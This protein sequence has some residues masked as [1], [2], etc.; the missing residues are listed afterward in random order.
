MKKIIEYEIVDHGV[1]HEQYFQGC[2][3]SHTKFDEVYTGIG[4]SLREAL[5]DAD[6][7]MSM[8]L[9]TYLQN[10]ELEE[11]IENASNESLI[12]K[13]EMHTDCGD[14]DCYAADVW[15]YA[16]IRVKLGEK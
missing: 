12:P 15:H 7:Q 4:S 10:D 13:E 5:R 1:E 11:E 14:D 3:V 16:S 6:E 8:S 9:G 2:G